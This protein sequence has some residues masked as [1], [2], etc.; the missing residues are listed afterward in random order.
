MSLP[1]ND[2]TVKDGIKDGL[3]IPQGKQV[4]TPLSAKLSV[5]Y[6]DFTEPLNP[7]R[8]SGPYHHGSSK[9]NFSGNFYL[10]VKHTAWISDDNFT[11]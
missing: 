11:R 10:Y 7:E 3:G 1:L 9:D 2:D 6:L 5:F 8:T 4:W